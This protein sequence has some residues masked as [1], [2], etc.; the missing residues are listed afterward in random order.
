MINSR[1][2][3]IR[4]IGLVLAAA[5]LNLGL[6]VVL[7]VA[8]PLVSG[9]VCGYFMLNPKWGALGGFLSSF[10]SSIPLLFLLE[11]LSP[12]AYDVISILIA[13]ILLSAIGALG[14]L[15]GGMIGIRTHDRMH[16]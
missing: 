5:L 13:A 8:A 10:I 15:I 3:W 7:F 16:S 1:D 6:Y 9:V 14:G 2:H 4:F 11:S 12:I